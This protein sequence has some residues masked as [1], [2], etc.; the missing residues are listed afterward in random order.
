MVVSMV[1]V[2][3]L[4]RNNKHIMECVMLGRKIGLD[5]CG[6]EFYDFGA[7]RAHYPRKLMTIRMA[8]LTIVCLIFHLCWP[9][10]SVAVGNAVKFVG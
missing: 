9:G 2:R 4:Y 5:D 8:E 10:F 7:G 6:I 1:P 3:L